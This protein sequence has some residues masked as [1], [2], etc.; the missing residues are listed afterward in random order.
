MLQLAVP[1]WINKI[2]EAGGPTPA[3]LKEA[4]ELSS[5]LGEKGDILLFG[6][7]KKGEAADQFNKTA[8][9]IAILAIICPGGIEI[10]DS[11]WEAPIDKSSLI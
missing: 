10:F 11:H 4:Q 2:K 7:G 3:D 1:L 9:A 5:V 8:K 6:G